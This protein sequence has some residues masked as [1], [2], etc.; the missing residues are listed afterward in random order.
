MFPKDI[1]ITHNHTDHSGELALGG[2]LAVQKLRQMNLPGIKL[3]ILCGPEVQPKLR[4]HRMD[5]IY[6]ALP[7]VLEVYLLS[8]TSWYWV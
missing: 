7:K 3:N 5:E 6:S 4:D 8:R 1:F 2:F